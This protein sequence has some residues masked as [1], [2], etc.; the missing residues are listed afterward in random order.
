MYLKSEKFK[1][2]DSADFV[3][4]GGFQNVTSTINEG[5]LKLFFITTANNEDNRTGSRRT[6]R[7]SKC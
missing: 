5:P 4:R 7:A 6:L 2:H 1:G 3:C